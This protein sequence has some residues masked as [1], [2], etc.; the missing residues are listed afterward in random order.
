MPEHE[1][2]AWIR[3]HMTPEIRARMDVFPGRSESKLLEKRLCFDASIAFLIARNGMSNKKTEHQV[4]FNFG[5]GE[6]AG[7]F[8]GHLEFYM[9]PPFNMMQRSDLIA[10]FGLQGLPGRDELLI[11]SG[12]PP[13]R[14]YFRLPGANRS[15]LELFARA[16][17]SVRRRTKP[18]ASL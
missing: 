17:R 2:L 15:P 11:A 7:H 8:P 9:R 12:H 3:Q 6:N 1:A 13:E 18:R 10:R 4:I 16:I 5:M 14:H